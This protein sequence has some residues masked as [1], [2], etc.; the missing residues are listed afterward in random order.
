MLYDVAHKAACLLH[1]RLE[2]NPPWKAFCSK[3]GQTKYQTQ[4]TELAFLVPP[5]QRSKARYM[6]LEALLTWAN[7]ALTVVDC[8]PPEIMR[9]CTA[10]R[11][12]EKFGWLRDY[13][14]DLAE[15]S[16]YQA[17]AKKAVH[18]TRCHGFYRGAS[19]DLARQLRP[20]I[21]TEAGEVLADEFI[22]FVAEQSAQAHEHER[23][24]GSSEVL[25]SSFGKFKFVEGQQAKGGF[26]ASIL[27]YAALLGTTTL[28]TVEQALQKV[29]HK[30]VKT[31]CQQHL[32]QTLPSKH[33][34][35]R[36]VL[37]RLFAQ[38]NSEECP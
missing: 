11:L 1:A 36:D 34:R 3:V 22:T 13:R 26:T 17:V 4:Q 2:R 21:R 12:E 31:W 20:V 16:E 5:T 32:G 8:Q 38:Q 14:D 15:W 25:E 7:R 29:Q 33:K 35:V 10:T 19:M 9:Y 30:H 24:P 28:D 6:N 37:R 18:F 27:A 23:L